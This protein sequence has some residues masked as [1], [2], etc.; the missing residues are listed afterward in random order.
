MNYYNVPTNEP[1]LSLLIRKIEILEPNKSAKITYEFREDGKNIEQLIYILEGQQYK[2]WYDDRYIM[3]LLCAKHG[4]TRRPILPPE[5][6]EKTLLIKN[7]DGTY[8]PKTETVK[9]PEYDANQTEETFY[10]FK[11]APYYKAQI[12]QQLNENVSSASSVHN[13]NDV[14]KIGDLE[15]QVANLSSKMSSMMT[16]MIQK[17]LV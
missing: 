5:F 1:N 11:G 17:G 14:A 2:E 7:D 8:T 16:I 12:Q 15:Q 9:N 13:P 10:E 4:L 6:I 3:D